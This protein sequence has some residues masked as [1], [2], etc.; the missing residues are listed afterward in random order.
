MLIRNWTMAMLLCMLPLLTWA[1]PAETYFPKQNLMSVGAYYYPEHWDSAQWDRD[2]GNMARMGFEFTH[3]AE[4][5][6]GF[7]EPQEGVYDFS[8]LDKAVALAAKHGLKV[9]MCTPTPC[10]PAWLSAK[11]PDVLYVTQSGLQVTHGAR[12]DYSVFNPV[13]WS[14]CER[15]ITKMAERYGNDPRIWGW[16]L[17]NEPAP[18]DDYSTFAHAAFRDWLK[19]K[20]QTIDNLNKTW[21]AAFWSLKYNSFD[22]IVIPNTSFLWGAS[23]HA[24]LDVKRF[25]ADYSSEFLHKQ[26]RVVRHHA[27]STQWI[28]TNYIS[29]IDAADPKRTNELDFLSYTIYPGGE[30]SRIGSPQHR[31][32]YPLGIQFASSFYKNTKGVTGVMELQPGQV[33]WSIINAQPQPGAVRMWLWHSFATGCSFA[34][35]YRYRQPLYGSEQYHAGIVGTD[36]VTPSPGGLEYQQVANEMKQLRKTYRP[37]NSIPKRLANN[38][39]AILWSHEILWETEQQKQTILWNYRQHVYK[40][41][42]A[43]NRLGAAADFIDESADFTSYKVLIAPAY[44]LLDSTLTTRW[45]KFVEN[46]GQLILTCRTGQKDRNAHLWQAKWAAPIIDLTGTQIPFFD[47][48]LPQ[49]NG[50]VAMGGKQYEWNCWADV[51]EPKKETE[52][53]ATYA[54]QF[55][56]GKAAVTSTKIGKGTVTYIGVDTKTGDLEKDIL[57]QVYQRMG[58]ETT[59]YPAGVWVN[60]RDGF[61]VA[62]N[63]TETPYQFVLP[64]NAKLLIGEQPLAP[65]GVLVWTE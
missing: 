63:Y 34:C 12:G 28:S 52:V 30:G 56:T 44:Q 54:N 13:Y 37:D 48:L 40:Y 57:Q 23:P 62:V 6:W 36:G 43:V 14:Y 32:G 16:Q 31:L 55:Y 26:Y 19:K 3:F 38:K 60:W 45:R 65:A 47:L 8:W 9:I 35:T 2:L 49:S 15:L 46:G 51:L 39:T 17:D 7:L 29:A 53:L 61:W 18:R 11:H 5:A 1:L 25:R 59:N 20:Y 33:N 27:R 64:K 10:P 4:F 24:L 58:V 22:Q 50:L 42:E 21:G 41:M